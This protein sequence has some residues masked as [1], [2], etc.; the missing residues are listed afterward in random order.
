M[1]MKTSGA[2]PVRAVVSG[3]A[4]TKKGQVKVASA[5]AEARVSTTAVRGATRRTLIP[6]PRSR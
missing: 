4:G 2:S 6:V 3:C 5:A 1:T